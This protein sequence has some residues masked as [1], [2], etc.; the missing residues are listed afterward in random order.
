MA[1][2]KKKISRRKFVETTGIAL[3]G[4]TLIPR[5]ALGGKG[6][7]A[8]SDQLNIAGVGAG[9]RGHGILNR[10]AK[11]NAS[12]IVALCDVDD[13]R[14]A[15]AYKKYDN[16]L[17]YKDFRVMLEKQKDI[18]AVMVATPDHTHAAV[19]MAAMQLGKHVYVEKPLTHNIYE[20][21]MLTEAAKRYKVATQMG[22]QGASGE[23][24]RKIIEWIEA[25]TIGDV[26]R[27]ICWTNRPI[28]P[29]GLQTP[30]GEH[31]IPEGL[32]WDLWLGPAP[33]RDYNPAYLPFRWRGWWDFG[34]GALGDMGCHVMDPPFRALKLGY[35]TSVE[36]SVG[37][38]YAGDFQLA[39]IPDSCPPS[40]K[41]HLEFP[42]R[43]GMPPVELIWYD[44]GIMPQR[45]E[46]L[47]P[48]EQMGNSDGG[49][50]FEG[51]KG[52]IMCG[53]YGVN[54]ILL[55]TKLQKEFEEPEPSIPRVPNGS[56]GHQQHWV[57]A[58]KEGTPT[59]SDFAYAGPFTEAVLMGNLGIRSY[60]IKKLKAGKTPSGWD[61]WKFPGRIKLNWD[62]ENMKI[63]NF[64]DANQFVK[65]K[66]RDGW[67]LGV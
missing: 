58:C 36:A 67:S 2:Y 43:E 28:W 11:N 35:P 50:I 4:I 25:G 20:A 17:R 41:V 31:E 49:V 65:R 53:T 60:N 30:K 32:D 22:N 19:A 66:Y 44:G 9:G 51:S 15:A 38:V 55:P 29:Q 10:A 1:K 18:D 24:V 13:N 37:Q 33:K 48:D 34:T 21:R 54:P 39:D 61:P 56:D 23:G 7:V 6:F 12:N 40:S 3:G 8:P 27:V 52:K 64:D 45:P 62:G 59:S 5:H 57:K 46:E 14:A 16:A 26:T 42:A 47:L 63:T